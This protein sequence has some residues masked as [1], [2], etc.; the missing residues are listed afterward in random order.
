MRA[1]VTALFD[2]P[3]LGFYLVAEASGQA[4][5]QLSITKEWSDWRN[6]N[7]WWIQSV[8]VM[9]DYR[10]RGVYRAMHNHVL[11][12]ARS[13]ADVCGLRLYVDR[14]NKVAQK[15][16]ACLDMQRSHYDLME[17]DFVL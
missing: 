12:E 2:N 14:D 11:A 7:F 6:S 8:Y 3:D 4:I 15:V 13:R 5:G 10:R 1:G 9:A 16:Y 17:I